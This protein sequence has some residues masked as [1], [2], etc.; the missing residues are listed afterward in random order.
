[1]GEPAFPKVNNT[2]LYCIAKYNVRVA[3]T[4]HTRYS[5]SHVRTLRN[6]YQWIQLDVFFEVGEFFFSDYPFNLK[7]P[8]CAVIALDWPAHIVGGM[9]ISLRCLTGRLGVPRASFVLLRVL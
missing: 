9:A 7:N 5:L 3:T 2:V 8:N 6:A 1:M 4:I